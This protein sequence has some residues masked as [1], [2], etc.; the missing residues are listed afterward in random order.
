MAARSESAGWMS[1]AVANYAH[2][3][4]VLFLFQSLANCVGAKIKTGL[5]TAIIRPVKSGQRKAQQR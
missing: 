2:I 5:T 4:Y 1:I 3:G